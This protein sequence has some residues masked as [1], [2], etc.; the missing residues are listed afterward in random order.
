MT[1]PPDGFRHT[2][3]IDI[4]FGDMDAMGHVN[5]AKYMTFMESG[6]IQ[7]FRD[8]GLWQG[9]PRLIGPI[10]AK[11]TVEYKLP[12]DLDD[13]R[14]EVFTRCA[15]LGNKSYDME[16]LIVRQRDGRAEVAAQ[17]TIVLVAFDYQ[18]GQSIPLPDPWREAIIAY[19]P[20]F[21]SKNVDA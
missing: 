21:A 5:N 14:I 1:T 20:L 17:G 7:Y 2:I 18:T 15:R 16:H 11:A 3:S 13:G 6:R 8:L 10:M 9:V 4:R 12:L 19:E